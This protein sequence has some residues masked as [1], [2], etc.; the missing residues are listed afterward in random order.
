MAGLALTSI[1]ARLVPGF[2]GSLRAD[3]RALVGTSA[4]VFGL[5][6][7]GA[8]MSAAAADAMFLSDLGSE[9]FGEAVAISSALLAVV[10][11][12]VGGLADRLERRRILATLAIASAVLLAGLAGLS[13]VAPRAAAALTF[14]GGKQLAAATDLAFWV[15]IAER[16][17][18]RRSRRI[19]PILAAG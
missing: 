9:H 14:V 11:A 3:E 12:V 18:A 7:A 19:V 10:L 8:A 17:D 1:G 13:L 4:V 15:V 2:L 16:L 6:S 5:A